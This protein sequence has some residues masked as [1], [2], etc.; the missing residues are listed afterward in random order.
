MSVLE[1]IPALQNLN[2]DDLYNAFLG[3]DRRGQILAATGVL[4]VLLT[5]VL[6]P[7]SLVSSKLD[8]QRDSYMKAIGR[9]DEI[10]GVL[11]EY[12]RLQKAFR[13]VDEAEAS[14]NQLQNLIFSLSSDSGI[15]I[16]KHRVAVKS[17][18]PVS[19]DVYEEISKE[20][21]LKSVP[22]DQGLRFLDKL[23]SSREI[24]VKI[25]KL[26]MTVEPRERNVLREIKFVVATI[27]LK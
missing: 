22:L 2:V 25:K 19:G 11:A 21:S 5:L 6:V 14:G 12:S 1:K 9:A 7:L 27:V 20:V 18:K 8:G 24:P 10:Y 23:S 15:D 3:M 4:L 26:D 17:Q 16:K 13:K